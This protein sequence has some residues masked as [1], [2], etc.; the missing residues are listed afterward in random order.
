MKTK[1]KIWHQSFNIHDMEP[2]VRYHEKEIDIKLAD[3]ASEKMMRIAIDGE[4]DFDAEMKKVLKFDDWRFRNEVGQEFE[5]IS[6]GAFR[7][8]LE[9]GILSGIVYV[10][11]NVVGRDGTPGLKSRGLKEDV[12]VKEE[13][14]EEL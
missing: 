9:F 6:K 7:I 14:L 5:D 11:R 4:K 3:E 2:I 8:L 1:V 12:F 10:W 13:E